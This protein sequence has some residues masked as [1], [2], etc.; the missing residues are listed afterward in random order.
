MVRRIISSVLGTTAVLATIG[1]FYCGMR[2]Q[3]NEP[4][5]VPISRP[6]AIRY[7]P[8]SLPTNTPELTYTS[9]PMPIPSPTPETKL[10]LLRQ[11]EQPANQSRWLGDYKIIGIG[12]DPIGA[13]I[14]FDSN[15]DGEPD[16][17]AMYSYE[18]QPIGCPFVFFEDTD[19]DA[20]DF[21]MVYW[22]RNQD[23]QFDQIETME[24]LA[25]REAGK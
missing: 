17:M 18:G 10:K 22:D 13:T 14:Y 23:C 3:Y 19:Y 24:D 12:N 15:N 21:D 20:E 7:T 1:T 2:E 4:K 9:T 11:I 5:R 8:T 16:L 25:T 6:T